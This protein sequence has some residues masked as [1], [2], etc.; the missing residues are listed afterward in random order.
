MTEM[1]TLMTDEREGM[2][3]T[4]HLQTTQVTKKLMKKGVSLFRE[5]G[6][7]HNCDTLLMI[8]YRC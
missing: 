5:I 6:K 1:I 3:T 7:A 8:D 4:E 2:T